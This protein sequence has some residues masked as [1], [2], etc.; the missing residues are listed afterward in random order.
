[1]VE[2]VCL[3]EAGGGVVHVEGPHVQEAEV[4]VLVAVVES[5]GVSHPLWG[6]MSQEN[7]GFLSI[8]YK[9]LIKY[10]LCAYFSK[11][12]YKMI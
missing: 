5:V 3:L 4:L 7:V 6:Q 8:H 11:I 1:M 10:V 9:P 2:G 12:T